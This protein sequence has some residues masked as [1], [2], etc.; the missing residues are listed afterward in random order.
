MAFKYFDRVKVASSTTGTGTI[1]LGTAVTGFTTFSAVY[2]NGDTMAYCISD[3]NGANWE[4]GTGTYVTAGNSLQRTSVL[5]SSNGGSLVNFTSALLYVFV[6][7][8]ANQFANATG[9]TTGSGSIVLS[10]GATLANPTVTGLSAPNAAKAWVN[11]NGSTGAIRDQ[12]NVASIT[13]N[14]TGDYLV[15]FTSALSN[16]N[17]AVVATAGGSAGQTAGIQSGDQLTARTTSL[18]R[19]LTFNITTGVTAA[20]FAQVNLTVFGN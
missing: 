13:K 17:Y 16:A 7:A 8:S 1:V 9:S 18:F 15:N 20:D 4:V 5:A 12:L 10:S 3:Q 2:S 19:L 6:V 11:F 14:G